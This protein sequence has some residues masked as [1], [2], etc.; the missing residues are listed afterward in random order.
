MPKNNKCISLDDLKKII[1]TNKI[2]DFL[3]DFTALRKLD[4]PVLFGQAITQNELDCLVFLEVIQEKILGQEGISSFI[5]AIKTK[6]IVHIIDALADSDIDLD[7]DI[8]LLLDKVNPKSDYLFDEYDENNFIRF[9]SR[10]L[11]F[12]YIILK[13]LAEFKVNPVDELIKDEL[14]R[15]L[16]LFNESIYWQFF[17]RKM[18]IEAPSI[19]PKKYFDLNDAYQLLYDE[20]EKAQAKEAVRCQE[21]ALLLT[22]MNEL[23]ELNQDLD[24]YWL[25]RKN[26]QQGF[27][28][29]FF[30]E[31]VNGFLNKPTFSDKK[32]AVHA[33]KSW[34][35]GEEVKITDNIV[36][37]LND[38]RLKV[39][40]DKI[41]TTSWY[42][43][44]KD[45]LI[46]PSALDNF[47]LAVL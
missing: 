31:K 3:A 33:L 25:E 35:Q 7:C 23:K 45:S 8:D 14:Y 47:N 13:N 24:Q 5:Q 21:S 18:E 34:L 29:S 20:Y 46:L 12:N 41:Q 30:N 17:L 28:Y 36:W 38:G 43:K 9:D 19:K 4:L 11:I 44:N 37:A 42:I 1:D 10:F 16:V 32:M 2:D 26:E 39:L 6:D 15:Y 27:S 40:F 22:Q